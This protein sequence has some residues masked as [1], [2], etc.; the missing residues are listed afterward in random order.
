LVNDKGWFRNARELYESGL[1]D[2]DRYALLENVVEN[3][4]YDVIGSY[5]YDESQDDDDYYWYIYRIDY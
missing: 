5:G 1:V 2:L 4:E 3:A